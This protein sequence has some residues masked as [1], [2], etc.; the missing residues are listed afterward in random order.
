MQMMQ[1]FT[2]AG[3]PQGGDTGVVCTHSKRDTRNFALFKIEIA[4]TSTGEDVSQ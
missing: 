3:D 1:G 4:A 2:V